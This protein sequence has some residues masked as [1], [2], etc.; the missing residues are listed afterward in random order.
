MKKRF[1]YKTIEIK[2][3]SMWT[4]TIDIDELD[5]TLNKFGMDGWEVVSFVPFTA[6]GTTRGLLYT[7]KREL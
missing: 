1:E 3:K 6:T 4:A 5:K 2:P 7:F